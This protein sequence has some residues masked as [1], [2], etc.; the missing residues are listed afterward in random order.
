MLMT[1]EDSKIA[2]ILKR[3]FHIMLILVLLYLLVGEILFPDGYGGDKQTAKRLE[4]A[5]QRILPD[6]SRE[7]VTLPADFGNPGENAIVLSGILPDSLSDNLWIGYPAN[8]QS[9][10]VTID[11]R[12]VSSYDPQDKRFFGKISANYIVMIPVSAADSGKEMRLTLRGNS[13]LTGYVYE[14]SIGDRFSLWGH[15]IWTHGRNLVVAVVLFIFGLACIIFST[16]IY[17][18][19]K[20]SIALGYLGWGMFLVAI[21]TTFESK[22]RQLYVTNIAVASDVAYLAAMLM[23]FP[24]LCYVDQ[25]QNRRYHKFFSF[26]EAVVLSNFAVCTTLHITG[27]IDLA[28]I[29]REI[30]IIIGFS[31]ATF[32]IT[33]V[34]DVC[35]GYIKEYLWV[36]IGFIIL[37]LA[38]VDEII[39]IMQHT[40]GRG[41]LVFGTA[42]IFIMAIVK[43]GQDLLQIEGEK[44]K[45]ILERDAKTKFLA[46]MS[47]EIRTPINAILG[48]NEMVMR[49]NKDK[50]IEGYVNDI[51]S[52]GHM[53]L[54]L[55][56]DILDLSK[57]DAGKMTIVEQPYELSSMLND[58]IQAIRPRIEKKCLEFH[59]EIDETLP[60]MYLGDEIRVKQIVNNLLTNAAK[61]TDEGSVTLRVAGER[62]DQETMI[63]RFT[64]SDTGQGIK[65]ENIDKLFESFTRLE[66]KKNASVEGTGLGL[67]IASHL[68]KQMNGTISVESVYGEGSVFAVCIPQVIHKDTPVGNIQTA[69]R[70]LHKNAQRELFHAPNALILIV[71]DNQM[72][73]HVATSLLKWTRIQMDTA[74]SGAIA[75]KMCQKKKYDLILMDHMM[76]QMDGVQTLHALRE[77]LQGL[78]RITPVIVLTA[79]AISGM[80]EWYF[81]QGFQ[82]YLSKPIDIRQLER[83]LKKHLP[84]KKVL[85]VEPADEE[86]EADKRTGAGVHAAAGEDKQETAGG[87]KAS[88]ERMLSFYEKQGAVQRAFLQ[89]FVTMENGQARL[90]VLHKKQWGQYRI[91]MHEMRCIAFGLQDEELLRK[92]RAAENAAQKLVTGTDEEIAGIMLSFDAVI[93]YCKKREETK[94]GL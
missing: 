51:E 92:T 21:W 8:R 46:N 55:I 28:N 6:G 59:V 1:K 31:F 89:R 49:E 39:R 73:L 79:N 54:A 50:N 90:A 44:Q 40:S 2:I 60:S 75:L 4:M 26:M 17:F 65:E 41:G 27:V 30:Q 53:L 19:F 33:F 11:G 38:T 34:L 14:L 35:H 68:L 24:F 67:H 16:V 52:A 72:N 36:G 5:W 43:T 61:Y 78:N 66:E 18:T 84:P 74:L 70:G 15:Y 47:H 58:M 76:P 82:D 63:L 48:M 56:N 42:V 83:T 86:A 94:N 64:V 7:D 10:T 13:K 69:H 20:R 32:V 9:V 3:I 22:I 87:S 12:Q 81:E 62:K 88:F 57:I 77:D 71:D 85:S 29:L 93:A 37:F 23:P 25:T 45:A 80:K 91:Y